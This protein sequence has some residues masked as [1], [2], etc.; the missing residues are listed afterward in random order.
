MHITLVLPVFNEEKNIRKVI[1]SVKKIVNRII[2]ID[3]NS[4]DNTMKLIKKLNKINLKHCYN[5]GKS[6][7]LKT[8]CDLAVFLKTDVIAFMDSDG[9][10]KGSD[11]QKL[12][13]TMKKEKVDSVIGYRDSFKMPLTRG[14]GTFLIK[15]LTNFLFNSTLKDIQSGMRIFKSKIYNKIKWT[16]TGSAHYFADAEISTKLIKKKIKFKEVLIQTIFLDKY[17]GMNIFQGIHLLFCL[18]LWRF[19]N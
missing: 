9:Q 18:V 13:E 8:G 5:L 15:I 4:S 11:L 2:V 10:H 3:N 19:N 7:S 6:N 12:I 16:S 1:T 14:I 17:K